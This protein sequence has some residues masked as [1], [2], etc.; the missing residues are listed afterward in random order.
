[1]NKVPTSI[2]IVTS[3][4]SNTLPIILAIFFPIILSLFC[5]I[6]YSSLIAL[7]ITEPEIL[8]ILIIIPLIWQCLP[9]IIC[10]SHRCPRRQLICQNCVLA[11]SRRSSNIQEQ[12]PAHASMAV[13]SSCIFS[14]LSAQKKSDGKLTLPSLFLKI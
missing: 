2:T 12:V 13:T 4:T 11:L 10:N 6:Y 3:T 14:S 5:V 1:M 8:K 9:Y 7:D